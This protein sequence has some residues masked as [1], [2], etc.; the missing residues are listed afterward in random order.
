MS[1]IA[2]GAVVAGVEVPRV[3]TQL[4]IDGEWRDALD[5]ATFDVVAP[6]TE[7]QLA[8]VA[9]ASAADV[10]L[11]VRA[12]RAQIDGGAWSQLSGADR[13]LLLYRLADLIER[14]ID[15]LATL[16][17]LDV[18]RPAFEPRMVDLPNVVDVFRHFGGWADKIEGR[19]IELQPFFGQPR[20]A[21]TVREPLG[22]IGA[23]TA[24][25]A[26]TLIASWKLAPALAA[27][28][29]VVL[30]PAEDASLST[31][32]LAA[33]IE[34]AGFPAGTVNVVT[35]LGHT[36]GAALVDHKGIDKLS[37]TGSPETGRKIAVAAA[38]E[39]RPVTLEL[40]GKSPQLVLGDA[41]LAAVV[42]GLAMGFL[43]NQGQICAAGTRILVARELYDD[44]VS[45]VA[46]AAKAV[47]LGGPFDPETRMGALI[48]ARQLERVTGYIAK[49]T[50]EGAELVTGGSRPDRPG[51]FVEPTVF[52]GGG[53]ETSI[54]QEEIFGPV[55]L[56]LPFDSIDEG[57]AQA[58]GTRYGLAAYV[59][60]RDISVAHS[61]AARLKAG[62][63]WINGSAPPDPRVPWGGVKSSGVGR[64]LGFAG[65]EANTEEK[66]VTIHL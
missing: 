61:V 34:E 53:H 59:W 56:V 27:G 49:G 28:N 19:W 65:I 46:E 5:G 7:E 44:V 45:G 60:T 31:L 51:Y 14:D 50:A 41:D 43:A 22:V 12:A 20:Q 39:F 25:N 52:A 8:Q 40:G 62:G 16:E 9:A 63:V 3:P 55:G 4:F 24:W 33:L 36:A 29:A 54:A 37:F 18:G 48:S 35:G 2:V 42:P 10:D 30:K 11:A 26:P 47:R 66:T 15:V 13:G 21:Y 57:I 38:Q 6:A 23:I 64:E 32:H 1:G 17:G 58:N